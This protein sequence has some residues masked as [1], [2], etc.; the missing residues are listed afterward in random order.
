MCIRDSYKSGGE[1][2]R[3]PA[4]A[5]FKNAYGHNVLL[6]SLHATSGYNGSNNTNGFLDK[7]EDQKKFPI[8]ITGGDF[9]SR[10][11][12]CYLPSTAT[13]KKGGALDGFSAHST[14]D[15]FGVEVTAPSVMDGDGYSMVVGEGFLYKAAG[16][17][18]LRLSDHAPVT[19]EMTIVPISGAIKPRSRRAREIKVTKGSYE[20]YSS[21]ESS[22]SGEG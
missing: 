20:G 6:T 10:P 19:T 12:S 3:Y 22:D 8:V 21:D 4:S 5:S 11:D 9:N 14:I 18:T 1:S 16:G 17:P 2:W 7:S 13:Q 15:D